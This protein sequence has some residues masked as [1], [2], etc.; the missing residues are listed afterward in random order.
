MPQVIQTII[1]TEDPLRANYVNRPYLKNRHDFNTSCL[2]CCDD[3]ANCCDVMWCWHLQISSQYDAI[4]YGRGTHSPSC[5]SCF[6]LWCADIFTCGFASIMCIAMTRGQIRRRFGLHS[7]CSTCCA[8]CLM[9]YFG[10]ACCIAC[11][12][13]RE[14]HM[15]GVFAGGCCSKPNNSYLKPAGS[16]PMPMQA[17]TY[18]VIEQPSPY[19]QPQPAPQPYYPDQP[20]YAGGGAPPPNPNGPA[21]NY[22][23]PSYGYGQPAYGQPAMGVPVQQC[24]PPQ[25]QPA[26]YY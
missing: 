11:Q 4:R 26:P 22:S 23:E 10:C 25:P 12:N 1:V 14:M 17:T 15:R 20:Y 24:Q 2:A 6:T 16:V 9:L 7:D 5:G 8:D 21:P 13:H 19:G 18:T 3:V